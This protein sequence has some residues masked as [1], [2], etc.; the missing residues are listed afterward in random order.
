MIEKANIVAKP[1]VT[2]T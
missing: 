1:V 2:A